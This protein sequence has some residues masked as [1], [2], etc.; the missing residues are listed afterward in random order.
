[1][2]EGGVGEEVGGVG[3]GEEGMGEGG[4]GER[5]GVVGVGEGGVGREGGERW[6]GQ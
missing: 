4:V 6:D 5:V 2:G 1:M 3:V